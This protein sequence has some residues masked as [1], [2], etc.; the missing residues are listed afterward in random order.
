MAKFNYV[1]SLFAILNTC[2]LPDLL[3][4]QP[5]QLKASVKT[6]PVQPWQ[7]QADLL[8]ETKLQL[9]PWKQQQAQL[10]TEAAPIWQLYCEEPE[11]KVRFIGGMFLS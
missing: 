3:W 8:S 10:L 6:Q 2:L 1:K 9:Q 11:P 7:H 5:I 4:E